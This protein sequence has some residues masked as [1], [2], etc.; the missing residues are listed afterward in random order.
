METSFFVPQK[1][2]ARV[3]LFFSSLMAVVLLTACYRP[4]AGYELWRA[5][6]SLTAPEGGV[7]APHM[8]AT[9]TNTIPNVSPP[10][11]TPTL[12]P[13]PAVTS[14][15]AAMVPTPTRGAPITLPTLRSEETVYE[16]KSGDSLANIA[17]AHQVSVKQI[18]D[19]NEFENPD[20]ISV[21]SML[22]IP[23]SSANKL[24]G[25]LLLVPDSELVYGP[26]SKDFDVKSF[27]AQFNGALGAYSEVDDEGKTLTG[28]QVVQRVADENSFNPRLLVAMLEFKTG[29]L[30]QLSPAGYDQ[31][32][33]LGIQAANREGL[34]KQLSW[35]ANETMRGASLW[36]MR[37]VAVWTLKDGEVVRID[38]TINEGTAGLQY[39]LGL[40]LDEAQFEQ[41]IGINGLIR[42]YDSLFGYPF[43]YTDHNLLPDSLVQPAWVL[44]FAEEDEWYFTS[45]PHWGWG[46][47][48]A[49]AAIDFAPPSPKEEW[50]CFE[51]QSPVLAIAN[52]RV[53]RSGFG[54]VVLDVDGDNSERTGW[55][56]LYL[57]I[58][59]ADRISVGA[60]VNVG[61]LIGYASCEG[62]VSTGTHIHLARKYNGVWIP[63]F[64][65][66]AFVLDGWTSTSTGLV[67]NGNLERDG[68][69]IEAYNGR[70]D[71][72]TI[73][74]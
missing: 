60:E 30:T 26:N 46:T 1:S 38:P 12:W 54:S 11:Q 19:E 61:D 10:A 51:S 63:A 71:F 31:K 2:Y 18:L 50:G 62:G 32:Y 20:L 23:P 28:P 69:T 13:T 27:I 73:G 39:A 74:R 53:V 29:W 59:E 15:R 37:A 5:S 49:W 65:E 66:T 34:Y 57:H 3:A 7:S 43:A 64:G 68:Q 6:G 17:L 22:R 40:L 67:Y 45:G 70:A 9:S 58:A 47:G 36:R 41:A 4:S 35:L 33:P 24:A 48:S 72:N 56:I 55:T 44:P 16:V 14:T 52:G 42:V 8:T 21:G 25:N